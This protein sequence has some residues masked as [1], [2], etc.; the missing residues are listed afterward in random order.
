MTYDEASR[1]LNWPVATVKSRLTKGRLRLRARLAQRGLGRRCQVGV[2]TALTG[3]ARAAVPQQ[4]VRSTARAATACATGALTAAVIVLTEGVLKMMM[5][6]KLKLVAVGTLVAVG[7]TAQAL[8]QQ[9]PKGGISRAAAAG[10]GATSRKTERQDG[11]RSPMGTEPA[12][13]SPHRGHRGFL[14]PLRPRYLV[15]SRRD[16]VTRA[17]CDP[18]EPRISGDD[19]VRMLVV[20]RLARIPEGADHRVVD[21]RGPGRGRGARLRDGKPLPDLSEMTALLPTDAGTCTVHF[22]VAAGPWKTIQ[23]WGK[24]PGGVGCGS[25]RVSSSVT[26]SQPRRGRRYRSLMTSGKILAARRDRQPGRG[27][28]GEDP[29]GTSVKDFRQ[30]VVEFDQTPSRS[31][32]SGSRPGPMKRLRFHGSLSNANKPPGS[33]ECH[34][35]HLTVALHT[36]GRVLCEHG[37]PR[38]ARVGTPG[39]ARPQRIKTDSPRNPDEP[40]PSRHSAEITRTLHVIAERSGVRPDEIASDSAGIASPSRTDATKPL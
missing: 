11:G 5:W 12:E 3:E 10:R 20:V 7:L 18:V 29:V 6:E 26:Q 4:L 36:G 14:L 25:M 33:E 23:K 16:A 21:H 24:N 31:R 30:I 22:K 8:S 13:R 39:A 2:A 27:S 35:E 40:I 28:P 37:S 15:A 17:P 19:A 1:Q 32:N 38:Q 9:A 34:L